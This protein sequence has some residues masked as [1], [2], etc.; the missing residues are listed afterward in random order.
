VFV[1]E[2]YP[3]RKGMDLF[4]NIDYRNLNRIRMHANEIHYCSSPNCKKHLF[5]TCYYVHVLPI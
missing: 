5:L 1:E 4:P 2:F 3:E